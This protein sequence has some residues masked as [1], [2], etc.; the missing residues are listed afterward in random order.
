MGAKR[1][2][3]PTSECATLRYFRYRCANPAKLVGPA[4]APKPGALPDC[5]TPRRAS[6]ASTYQQR[7]NATIA[8]MGAKRSRPSSSGSFVLASEVARY[9]VL[10]SDLV[11]QQLL[12]RGKST[13][14]VIPRF[15]RGEPRDDSPGAEAILYHDRVLQFV[16]DND[17]GSRESIS[18][19][20][21]RAGLPAATSPRPAN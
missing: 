12:V 15:Q 11:R 20:A 21:V 8:L 16:D 4:D 9:R 5:A 3:N 18:E 17:L 19:V 1:V 10:I 13:I 6:A 14:T 7:R 2:A